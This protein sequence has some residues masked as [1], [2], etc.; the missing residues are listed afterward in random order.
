MRTRQHL[1]E[2][3]KKSVNENQNEAFEKP[4]TWKTSCSRDTLVPEKIIKEEFNGDGISWDPIDDLDDFPESCELPM[5]PRVYGVTTTFQL[6]TYEKEEI[7]EGKL[8]DTS[9]KIVENNVKLES[10][11]RNIQNIFILFFDSKRK[12]PLFKTV[13]AISMT[14]FSKYL[15]EVYR[16][17]PQET[18]NV[19]TLPVQL[20]PHSIE[21]ILSFS[22][23]HDL[24]IPTKN[25]EENLEQF[26]IT[27][28]YFNFETLKQ[29]I[30][31]FSTKKSYD[32]DFVELEQYSLGLPKPF[33]SS[34]F[35]SAT[36]KLEKSIKLYL[37]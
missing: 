5:S 27:A 2:Y 24:N 31:E 11:P 19:L 37:R 14:A 35:D 20:D 1:D 15:T 10:L 28:S 33:F 17:C 26:F 30:Q 16:N 6:E 18:I 29:K 22:Q 7:L 21:A 8:I 34:N 13:D 3:Y 23:G 9:S 12:V 25:Q 36:K 32:I 4:N